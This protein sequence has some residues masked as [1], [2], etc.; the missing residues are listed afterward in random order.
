MDILTPEQ[1][2]LNM[3][4]IK[5]KDTKPEMIVR[6]YLFSKGLRFRVHVKKLAVFGHF[7]S[8]VLGAHDAAIKHVE[9]PH[10]IRMQIICL[11]ANN[12]TSRDKI[13]PQAIFSYHAT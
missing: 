10:K 6:K 3:A 13:S 11:G 9:Q 5:G 2:S 8:N 7:L 4:A 12:S 1:R